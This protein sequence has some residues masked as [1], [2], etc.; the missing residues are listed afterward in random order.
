MH[1]PA[2][3]LPD[4][5]P[6]PHVPDDGPEWHVYSASRE[7]LGTWAWCPGDRITARVVRTTWHGGKQVGFIVER[8]ASLTIGG[9]RRPIPRGA[10]VT[11]GQ[12]V[13]FLPGVA[14]RVEHTAL[15]H[16]EV[17]KT[18]QGA[19]RIRL[20]EDGSAV[21]ATFDDPFELASN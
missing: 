5:H 4:P 16:I 19:R 6:S 12:A 8:D 9:V 17:E 10:F 7:P 14:L 3:F 18:S 13:R 15:V 21:W 20:R 1:K 2:C 11:R